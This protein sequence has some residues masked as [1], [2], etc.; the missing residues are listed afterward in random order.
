[1][2]GGFEPN[3]LWQKPRPD[4]PIEPLSGRGIVAALFDLH[5]DGDPLSEAR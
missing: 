4:A 1:M 3:E 5:P 2:V